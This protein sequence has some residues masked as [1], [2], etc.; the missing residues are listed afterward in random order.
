M[1]VICLSCRES[2]RM[3]PFNRL[4]FVVV[5]TGIGVWI[6]LRGFGIGSPAAIVTSIGFAVVMAVG[7][8]RGRRPGQ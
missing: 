5:F 6:T 3:Q 7:L 4:A 1:A 2:P 8:L